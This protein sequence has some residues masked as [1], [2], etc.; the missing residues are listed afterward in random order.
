MYVSSIPHTE[1]TGKFNVLETDLATK[2]TEDFEK[3]E[4]FRVTTTSKP[5]ASSEIP[6][7]NI[8]HR[9]I[10][11]IDSEISDYSQILQF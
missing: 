8:T 9:F 7:D 11:L 1:T 10:F 6:Y 2:K 4:E 3:S 5:K